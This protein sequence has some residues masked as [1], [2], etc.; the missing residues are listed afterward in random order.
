M[1]H[2]KSSVTSIMTDIF[3]QFVLFWSI[4]DDVMFERYGVPARDA[5]STNN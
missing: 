1:D 3:N 4:K 2:D 5:Y